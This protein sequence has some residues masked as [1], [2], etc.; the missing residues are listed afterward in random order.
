MSK[1]YIP[2]QNIAAK[3]WNEM[4]EERQREHVDAAIDSPIS[5]PDYVAEL[6]AVVEALGRELSI[7]RSEVKELLGRRR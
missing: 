2:R 1:S 3:P 4:T 6:Q 7:L 5:L